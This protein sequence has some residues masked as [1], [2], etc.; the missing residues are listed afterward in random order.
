MR[1][2]LLTFRHRSVEGERLHQRCRQAEELSGLDLVAD[3][4]APD[5]AERVQD[6]LERRG[7][8]DR[9]RVEVGLG[10][11]F[12]HCHL[13]AHTD[14][15]ARQPLAVDSS[16]RRVSRAGN[17]ERHRLGGAGRQPQSLSDREPGELHVL[18]AGTADDQ[19]LDG[20]DLHVALGVELD[21][22]GQL[23]AWCGAG[24]GKDGVDV[25]AA[26]AEAGEKLLEDHEANDA[27]PAPG[28][29]G[30]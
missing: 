20:A 11:A 26:E 24:R 5:G 7:R 2:D 19:Q 10:L 1:A 6:V 29:R 14:R 4:A 30:T 16:H 17:A 23:A 13:G 9:E 15:D 28:S 18:L 12:V 21:L 8:R 3:E 25:D 22:T 27:S